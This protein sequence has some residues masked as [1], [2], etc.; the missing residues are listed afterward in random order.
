MS[1]RLTPMLYMAD[2][3]Y[4]SHSIQDE[5][6]VCW[7]LKQCKASIMQ[8]NVAVHGILYLDYFSIYFSCLHP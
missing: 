4:R 6:L 5:W 1:I 2:Q 3:V 8:C 7:L